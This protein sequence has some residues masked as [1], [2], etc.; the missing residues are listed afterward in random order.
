MAGTA[1][2]LAMCTFEL[3]LQL[4]RG[5]RSRICLNACGPEAD[6]LRHRQGVRVQGL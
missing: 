3:C 6:R 1:V 5:Q 4:A 2:P